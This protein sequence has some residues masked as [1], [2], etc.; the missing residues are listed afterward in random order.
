MIFAALGFHPRAWFA[1]PLV[2]ALF[3]VLTLTTSNQWQV[4]AL[5]QV[6]TDIETALPPAG[7]VAEA[8]EASLRRVDA[9][10]VAR[11]DRRSAE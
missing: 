6:F 4:L 10:M 3:A 11:S 8:R 1:A 2:L 9:G 7:Q 5:P